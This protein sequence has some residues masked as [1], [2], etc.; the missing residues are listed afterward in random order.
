MA[1]SEAKDDGML[2]SCQLMER[3]LVWVVSFSLAVEDGFLF[4]M[5]KSFAACLIRRQVNFSR[6]SPKIGD[7]TQILLS[8]VSE[9]SHNTTICPILLFD[10][11]LLHLLAVFCFTSLLRFLEGGWQVGCRGEG[12]GGG[13][14]V[15]SWLSDY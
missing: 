9:R 8:R 10:T 2:V 14:G 7:L 15:S 11:S 13:G 5:D 6:T 1:C 12:G 4:T 3:V